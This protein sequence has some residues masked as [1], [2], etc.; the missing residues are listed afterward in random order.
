M[1]S[2]VDPTP[3][4]FFVLTALLHAYPIYMSRHSMPTRQSSS[5]GLLYDCI[6]QEYPILTIEDM[7]TRR[8]IPQRASMHQIHAATSRLPAWHT[9]VSFNTIFSVEPPILHTSVSVRMKLAGK[10]NVFTLQINEPV[11]HPWSPEGRESRRTCFETAL[12]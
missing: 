1:V 2:F 3:V 6:M 9:K 11:R 4:L 7:T 8:R 5:S 10:R 12:F